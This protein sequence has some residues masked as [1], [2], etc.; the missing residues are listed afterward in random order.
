MSIRTI[1]ALISK[2]SKQVR[3]DVSSILVALVMPLIVLS[4]FGFGISFNIEDI[5]LD[6]VRQDS[7]RASCDLIDLYKNSKYFKVNVVDSVREAEGHIESGASQ[8]ALILS[9]KFSQ[10]ISTG[11]KPKI[12]IVSDGTDPNTASYSGN[13]LLFTT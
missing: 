5:G 12:Q 8:G 2:E 11:K 7:G 9:P 6:I 3:R 4:V 1:L 13:S 10:Q